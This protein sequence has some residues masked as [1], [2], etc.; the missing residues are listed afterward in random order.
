MLARH[1]VPL[2]YDTDRVLAFSV[3][4]STQ[5]YSE[6]RTRQFYRDALAT[7]RQLPGASSAG[8]AWI[9]PFRMIGGGLGLKRANTPGATEVIGDTNSISDGFLPTLG[10]RFIAGRD[11]TNTEGI[12][13]LK[14]RPKVVIV[15]ETMALK[16]FGTTNVVGELVEESYD[17]GKPL[18][19][20]GVI[21]NIRTRDV[22]YAPAKPAAYTPFGQ[23]FM[24]GWGTLHVRFDG[25][26]AAMIPRVRDAI[27]RVDTQLPLYDIETLS[28]AVDRHLAE[29]RLL[30]KTVAGFAL[31]ATV[32]AALGLYGVLSRGVSERRREFGIRA[33][34]GAA[35]VSVAALVTREAFLLSAAGGVA[36]VG[37]AIW[38]SRFLE[39]RLFGVKAFDPASLGIAAGIA[40]LMALVA[41]AAPARRAAAVNV[42]EE[43]R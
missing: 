1:H 27:R 3:D 21:A 41:A 35:P 6:E 4:A 42:V 36:G 11:F 19:I 15:N 16:L 24:S 29:E 23:S 40:L 13:A 28:G 37:I 14:G 25:P 38:I 18:T 30:S 10:V 9:E 7:L 39:S 17:P 43:L 5:G 32:V 33:A 20:V 26:A 34:L 22:S 12:D 2:G 8:Y 31:I